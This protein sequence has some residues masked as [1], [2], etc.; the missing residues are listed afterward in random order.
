TSAT[1]LLAA[2][3]IWGT[4]RGFGPFAG[5]GSAN[6]SLLLLHAFI[7]TTNITTLVL[8][9]AISERR[10]AQKE[11]QEL[12]TAVKVSQQRVQDIVSQAPGVVWE[13]WG[14]PDAA[15]QRIGFVSNHVEK[16][17]GYSEAEWLSTPNFWLSIVHP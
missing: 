17:L 13:A 5:A 3:A 7:D 12:G 11:K 4:A 1:L 14:E 16:M 8:F 9:A 15:T 2:V 6:E 10:R